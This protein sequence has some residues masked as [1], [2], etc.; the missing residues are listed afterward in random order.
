[1]QVCFP[2]WRLAK[3]SSS[4]KRAPWSSRFK[5][6]RVLIFRKRLDR[7]GGGGGEKF[8][9]LTFQEKKKKKHLQFSAALVLNPNL[10]CSTRHTSTLSRADKK[11]SE[12]K[13][14]S[15]W[16]NIKSKK[17]HSPS[18]TYLWGKKT[19]SYINV[20]L[21]AVLCPIL[22]GIILPK[23]TFTPCSAD[24]L[25][26]DTTQAIQ[27]AQRYHTD[28]PAFVHKRYNLCSWGTVVTTVHA[29]S[30]SCTSPGT[31]LD[32]SASQ[33]VHD[34]TAHLCGTVRNI[35]TTTKP[36]LLE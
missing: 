10:L 2:V 29:H 8:H 22:L 31:R 35:W 14:L 7:G 36:P 28:I 16:I 5:I 27:M 19:R 24:V 33:R 13:T 15:A 1:M 4:L 18:F 26:L 20:D 3:I 12:Q 21:E 11:L 30:H 17:N 23:C 32:L 34:N 6:S 25:E 9:Q